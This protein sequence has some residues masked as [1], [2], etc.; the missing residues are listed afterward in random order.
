ML[1]YEKLKKNIVKTIEEIKINSGL[2]T[3]NI[4]VLCPICG[5]KF[6]GYKKYK[7]LISQQHQQNPQVV[8]QNNQQNTKGIRKNQIILK[9]KKL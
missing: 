2:D 1:R 7:H 8:G 4:R 6:W 5:G 9:K 3:S